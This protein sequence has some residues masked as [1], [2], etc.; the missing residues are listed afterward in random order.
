[1]FRIII[2]G[3]LIFACNIS[4][5]NESVIKI[6]TIHIQAESENSDLIISEYRDNLER[7]I[8]SAWTP[9]V[10]SAGAVAT[11]KLSLN[12]Q[13]NIDD[14]VVSSNNLEMKN[15]IEKAIKSVLPFDKPTNINI[16]NKVRNLNI[17]F[18]SK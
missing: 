11:V 12:D 16:G 10:G 8:F 17:K 14:L 4:I 9:P 13:G 6:P 15:S 18:Q 1:M 3:C 2:I 7:K 5:A